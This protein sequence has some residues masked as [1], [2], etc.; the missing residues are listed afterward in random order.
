MER[1]FREVTSDPWIIGMV[2]FFGASFA[3]LSTQLRNG[4]CLTW[5]SVTAAM[6]NSGILGVIIFLMGYRLFAGNIPY[7]VGLCLLAGIGSA[8]TLDLFLALW[9][10]RSCV[11]I[12]IKGGE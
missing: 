6:L 12:T 4:K 10:K 9:K 7:L 5:R 3:G 2:A 8:T 11:T 1:L